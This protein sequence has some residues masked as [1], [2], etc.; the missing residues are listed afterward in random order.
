MHALPEV[1]EAVPQLPVMLDSGVRRGTDVIK[2][3]AL[4]ARCVF[5]GRP[6]AYAAAVASSHGVT[7]GIGLMQA[8]LA[9]LALLGV[10]RVA[11]V[12]A[13]CIQRPAVN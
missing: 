8:E 6:F 1:V 7:H 9:R 2:A 12:G 5:I 11:D 4:G 13:H 3:L 10:T